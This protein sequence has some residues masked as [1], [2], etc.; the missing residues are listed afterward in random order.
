MTAL[1]RTRREMTHRFPVVLPSGEAVLFTLATGDTPTYDDA[2]IA[3]LSIASGEYHV[4]I[5]GGTGPRYSPTGHIVYARSASLLAVPFDV[6]T[7]KVTGAPVTV[8]E[9]VDS[10]RLSTPQN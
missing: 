9:S 4:L 1:D 2:S 6:T 7:L 5:E 3:I 10:K 8:L